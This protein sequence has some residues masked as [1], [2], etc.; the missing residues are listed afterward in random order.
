MNNMNNQELDDILQSLTITSTGTDT[1]TLGSGGQ[2]ITNGNWNWE[3]LTIAKTPLKVIGDAEIDGQ[4]KVGGKN[5]GELL[6]KIEQRLAILTPNPELEAKWEELKELGE[7][8]RELEKDI[9]EK[10]A[11]YK[12]LSR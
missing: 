1:I 3:D 6:D 12:T 9:L 8:Y 7:R 2:Y 4:L 11:I 10:E 5:I